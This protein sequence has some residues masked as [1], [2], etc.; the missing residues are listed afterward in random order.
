MR[1]VAQFCLVVNLRFENAKKRAEMRNNALRKANWI[2]SRDQTIPRSVDV[3]GR[4]IE[5]ELYLIANRLAADAC[6]RNGKLD[7]PS[8]DYG[9]GVHRDQCHALA[10]VEA[11]SRRVIVG[12]DQPQAAAAKGLRL[13]PGSREARSS[14]CHGLVP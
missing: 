9:V 13:L 6:Q 8:I 4:K 7:L 10:L 14:P 5:L 12:G 3:L 11:D 1:I 2:Q